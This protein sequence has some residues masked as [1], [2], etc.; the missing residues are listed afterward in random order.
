[1]MIS[2][3]TG[4]HREWRS[5][6]LDLSLSCSL[7]Y[8]PLVFQ[9]FGSKLL[10][11]FFGSSQTVVPQVSSYKGTGYEDISTLATISCDCILQRLT[12]GL[13][14]QRSDTTST[15]LGLTFLSKNEVYGG[16]IIQRNSTV[17]HRFVTARNKRITRLQNGSTVYR[18][19][20]E[21][22][23]GN[24]LGFIITIAVTETGSVIIHPWY[25]TTEFSHLANVADVQ[26]IWYSMV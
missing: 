13:E 3:V 20:I 6:T 11:S 1:M 23:T 2:I 7:T 10:V 21:R 5:D 18:W 24:D 9:H 25:G 12:E 26:N 14:L 8:T 19:I 16:I 22:I 4:Q 17:F 15:H